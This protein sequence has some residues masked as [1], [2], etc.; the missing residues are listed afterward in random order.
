ME[1]LRTLFASLGTPG[2]V[3][4]AEHALLA[5]QAEDRVIALLTEHLAANDAVVAPAA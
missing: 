1:T 4:N 5:R 3:R 2:A